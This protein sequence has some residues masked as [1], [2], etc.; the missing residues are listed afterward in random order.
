MDYKT[1]YYPESRFGGFSDIDGAVIFYCRVNALLD[2]D[3]VVLD[4]GCGRGVLMEDNI[5]FRKGLRILKGKCLKVIGIDV[6][7]GAQKNPF[8]DEFHLITGEQWPLPDHSVDLGI[9]I[10]VLEHVENP[11]AFFSEFK[12]VIKPGGY[13]C[14]LTGNVLSYGGAM[15]WLI[16][17]VLHSGL[18]KRMQPER[19]EID[20]FPKYYRCNTVKKIRRMLSKYG[21]DH[22]VYGYEAE[23]SYVSF[24]RFFYFLG[25]LHQKF[26]PKVIKPAIFAF[27]QSASDSTQ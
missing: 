7:A 14:L 12:R 17:D 8:I 5:P 2:S 10:T 27:A 25:V 23:P 19:E 3:A 22:C 21:F 1:L 13:L 11:D 6:D 9:S 15:S 16:P 24:F 20:I 18:L 4:V 26:S